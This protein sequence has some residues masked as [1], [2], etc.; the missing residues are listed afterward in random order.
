MTSKLLDDGTVAFGSVIL[1]KSGGISDF[2]TLTTSIARGKV[3]GASLFRKIGRNGD[4]DNVREDL[5]SEGGVY[6]LPP[7]GGIQMS[8]Q[9]T[10]ANDSINGTGVRVVQIQYLDA[11]GNEK[12]ES[13]NLAGVT[14]TLTIATDIAYVNGISATEEGSLNGAAGNVTLTNVARNIVYAA[15]EVGSGKDR[16]AV[17][18]VPAGKM[19]FVIETLLSGNAASGSGAEYLEGFLRATCDDLGNKLPRNVFNFKSGQV[20]TNSGVWVTQQVPIVLP[21]LSTV[22][23]SVISRNLTSNVLAIGGFAGWLEPV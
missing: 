19:A 10:N 8:V 20:Q 9:S 12:I 1:D 13:V 3:T 22:K 16:Q 4:V 6:T 11:N 15:I 18:T 14:P 7:D 21:P 5:W 23:L 2:Q 17:F